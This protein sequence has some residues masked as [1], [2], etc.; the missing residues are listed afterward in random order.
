MLLHT[1]EG[2]RGEVSAA[3]A[4]KV[5][6]R[7][8]LGPGLHVVSWKDKALALVS[9]FASS[10]TL[11]CCA[12]PTLLV[13]LGLGAVVA[14]VVSSLPWLVT[15]SQ[16]KEWVFLGAGLLIAGNWALMRRWERAVTSCAI[17]DGEAPTASACVVASRFSRTVLWISTTLYVVGFL[18]A[19]LTLPVG[20]ALGWL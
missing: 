16:Q 19:F 17:P 14:G 10:S 5:V 20:K 3:G 11:V 4:R 15:L 9:L 18:V 7:D 6:S 1:R 8:P 2:G 13:A 12:L